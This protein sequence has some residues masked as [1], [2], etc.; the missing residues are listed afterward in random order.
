MAA[1]TE[2]VVQRLDPKF[3]KSFS[4]SSLN[5]GGGYVPLACLKADRIFNGSSS[6]GEF[7][8]LRL[9][10]SNESSNKTLV[11]G[12]FL[13]VEIEG[14]VDFA[15][16]NTQ[17]SSV[18]VA[19]LS[20]T[21]NSIVNID[22]ILPFHEL[23]VGGNSSQLDNLDNLKFVFGPGSSVTVAV[24]TTAAIDGTIGISWFEQQ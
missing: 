20:P 10:A 18:S 12:L 15:N 24:K 3:A 16:I 6:F 23:F 11:I 14:T 19:T 1:F 13:N 22:N 5:S 4:F 8:L 7:D 17:Q 2:G 9:Q 21:V